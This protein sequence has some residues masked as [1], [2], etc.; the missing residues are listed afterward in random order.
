MYAVE[1]VKAEVI[2]NHD[3][4]LWWSINLNSR[5]HVVTTSSKCT[6][7]GHDTE[8]PRNVETTY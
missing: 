2:K 3:N 7:Y 5:A 4:N 6:D 1:N 8:N